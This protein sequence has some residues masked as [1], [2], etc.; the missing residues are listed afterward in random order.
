M[1]IGIDMEKAKLVAMV[2]TTVAVSA[3]V[4]RSGLIGFV[5]L[6]IPHLAEIMF[7]GTNS[8][9]SLHMHCLVLYSCCFR[10]IWLNHS[11]EKSFL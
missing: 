7:G 11:P 3:A 10:T 2:L 5:D 6:V 8:K 9:A 4:S 1:S